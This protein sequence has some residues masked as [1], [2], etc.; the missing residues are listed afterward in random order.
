M[1][2]VFE[3]LGVAD[4]VAKSVGTNNP[5]NMVRATF[6]ALQGQ[7]SPKSVAQRR[8]RKVADLLARRGDIAAREAEAEADALVA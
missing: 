7:V 8:G 2:A 4:V 1:R 3:S 6:A 5:Y